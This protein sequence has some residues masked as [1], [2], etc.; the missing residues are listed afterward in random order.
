MEPG[1]RVD[2]TVGWLNGPMEGEEKNNGQ[3]GSGKVLP[4]YQERSRRTLVRPQQAGR[5][6]A[7][8]ID[9]DQG[10]ASA[11]APHWASPGRWIPPTV[12]IGAGVSGSPFRPDFFSCFC[13]WWYVHCLGSCHSGLIQE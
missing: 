4:V 11:M 7:W 13:W 3:N 12:V 5:T 1:R 8:E 6:N 10:T 9:D 2:M